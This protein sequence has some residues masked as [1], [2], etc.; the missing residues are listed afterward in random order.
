MIG[1]VSFVL[2]RDIYLILTPFEVQWLQRSVLHLT[3]THVN[4]QYIGEPHQSWYKSIIHLMPRDIFCLDPSALSVS[5]Y[6]LYI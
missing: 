5:V 2:Q 1:S 3:A 6:N 4:K